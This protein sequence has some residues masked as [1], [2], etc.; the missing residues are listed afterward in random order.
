MTAPATMTT[1]L[2]AAPP[3]EENS[4]TAVLTRRHALAGACGACAVA[5][6]GCAGYGKGAAAAP[7]T[8][9]PA[10]AAQPPGSAAAP[11]TDAGG[12]GNG[13]GQLRTTDVPVGGGVVLA[14]LGVVVTQPQAGTFKAFSAVCTHQGCTVGSVD[15]GTINCPCHGSAFNIADGSVAN[16]PASRP[17]DPKKI[18]VSG[19]SI[20]VS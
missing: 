12:S 6:V 16:G 9:A 17:L 14:D 1:H 13:G 15:N 7:K 5:L 11:A 20:T 2:P 10:A 4:G 8:T 18:S 3:V 19:T